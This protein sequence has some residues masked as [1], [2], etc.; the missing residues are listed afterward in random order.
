MS[1][2]QF[3]NLML[4]VAR[5]L[6]VCNKLL[7]EDKK[8]L[9][10]ENGKASI[11]PANY[12]IEDYFYDDF[13]KLNN[14]DVIQF[15]SKEKFY[16]LFS[17]T[18]ND[19]V[20]F[21]TN[22]CNSNCI[23]C[24]MTESE[25]KREN[26]NSK[27]FLLELINYLPTDIPFITITGGEPTLERD[28]FLE[29]LNACKNHFEDNTQFLLLTNGRS[30]SNSTYYRKMLDVMPENI[31]F[32]IPI[33]GENAMLHDS[34]TRVPGSFNQTVIG[35]KKLLADNK[36]VEIRIVVSKKNY[37]HMDDI[38]TMIID[39]FKSVDVVQ[40]MALEMRG[41]AAK[42]RD[43]VWVDYSQAFQT[44]SK[45]IL[46]LILNSINVQLYN[47]PLCK[48][49]KE[50]WPICAKSISDYKIKYYDSCECCS[51]KSICGGVFNTTLALTKMELNPIGV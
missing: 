42:N 33:Y 11:L 43:D 13:S 37:L 5:D 23:M 3:N 19:P 21:I 36:N 31:T 22:K 46:K 28:N 15:K 9:F 29:V 17:S 45:A 26:S 24:P 49:D 18:S 20:L 6:S 1:D 38:S 27:E 14:Y 50:Y 39:S 7:N 35:I 4:S 30:L 47:F 8:V 44:S 16:I 10:I 48:V 41:C 51:V 32:G 34:I 2:I 12:I 40:I 25:R